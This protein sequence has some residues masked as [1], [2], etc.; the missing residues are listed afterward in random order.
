MARPAPARLYLPPAQSGKTHDGMMTAIE[1]AFGN[2]M[3]L[4]QEYGVAAVAIILMLESIG[5]PLPGESLLILASVLAARGDLSFPSLLV[6]AWAGA[7]LGDNIGYV[8]GRTFGR[9]V[10]LRFGGRIGI[11]ADRL[12]KVEAV[13]ARYVPVTVGFARFFPILRQLNGVVAGTLAME[14]RRFLL[15]NALGGALWVLVWSLLGFY[16]G[17][18][19]GDLAAL[20]HDFGM[21]GAAVAA[22]V[23]ATVAWLKWPRRGQHRRWGNGPA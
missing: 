8:I 10:V 21:V 18:H 9:A 12:R 11:T 13:F 19:V 17:A 20:A 3:P 23:V 6:L 1:H 4:L 7:V 15:F 16:L 22:A 2:L 14:W 5:L